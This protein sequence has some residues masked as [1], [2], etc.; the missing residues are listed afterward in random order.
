MSQHDLTIDNDSRTNVR[1]DLQAALQALGSCMKGPS[2]PATPYVGELWLDDDTPSSTV[3]TLKRYDGTDWIVVSVIDT[4]ANTET[5]ALSVSPAG[6]KGQISGWTWANNSSDPTN[7][8]DIAAGAGTD[9]TGAAVIQGVA[10]TK[11]YDATW[12]AGNGNGGRQGSAADGDWWIHAIFD[13][14]NQVVDYQ[15]S[16]SRTAPTLP[17]GYTLF[18]P[19]G[20]FQVASSSIVATH[21]YEL[22]GG[23]IEVARDTRIADVNATVGTVRSLAALACVPTGISVGVNLDVE[24]V[25]NGVAVDVCCPDQAATP[26]F[27]ASALGVAGTGISMSPGSGTVASVS[28][29]SQKR[30]RTNTS[31]EVALQAGSNG[32]LVRLAVESF[33]WSRR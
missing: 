17:S 18:R 2:A 25:G 30:T 21:S 23:G 29:K 8:I 15:F 11:R 9:T 19:I 1:L 3:W 32:Q 27:G 31:R 20:W 7:D 4:V 24:V 6:S 28:H 10:L 12:S 5:P 14:G 16:Q 22:P 33:E 13:V 26:V